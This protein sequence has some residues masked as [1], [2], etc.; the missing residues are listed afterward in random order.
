MRRAVRRTAAR[1]PVRGARIRTPRT[2]PP[3]FFRHF[4]RPAADRA[5]YPAAES[6]RTRPVRFP[7]TG[8]AGNAGK[9]LSR[10]GYCSR[11]DGAGGAVCAGRSWDPRRPPGS[12]GGTGHRRVRVV[13]VPVRVCVNHSVDRES[14]TRCVVVVVVVVPTRTSGKF[15]NS[16]SPNKFLPEEGPAQTVRRP[17]ESYCVLRSSFL[18]RTRFRTIRPRNI[19]CLNGRT[20]Q[21][22]CVSLCGLYEKRKKISNPDLYTP[23]GSWRRVR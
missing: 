14:E 19:L 13:C 21:T 22:E 18:R 3:C 8:T 2:R 20:R 11:P 12:D 10:D 7:A 16:S 23:R 17:I 4:S 1:P 9:R 5:G 15:S 6:T